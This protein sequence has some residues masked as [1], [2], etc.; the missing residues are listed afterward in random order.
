[1]KYNGVNLN[2]VLEAH[3]KWLAGDPEG[4]RADFSRA[5]LISED[6]SN[7]D[8]RKADLSY[9]FLSGVNL[10][11]TDLT[12]A[13]IIETTFDIRRF[14]VYAPLYGGVLF[15]PE[16]KIDHPLAC[17]E[18]GSFTAYKAVR[19]GY[20][21]ELFIPADAKRSSST[22]NKCRCDKAKV[23]SIQNPDGGTADADIVHSI[24]NF[25]F[26]Y[27]VG[28]MVTVPDFDECRWHECAP[29]IH[30]FVDREDAVDYLHSF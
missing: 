1:M 25:D 15:S 4:S 20:I 8:L 29:G 16:T 21:V 18:T 7:R 11:G 6:L 28:E 9:S 26:I 2:E 3:E 12:G 27:R 10:S 19:D 17:P 24:W 13:N 22:S 14:L 5:A 23:V 30:F